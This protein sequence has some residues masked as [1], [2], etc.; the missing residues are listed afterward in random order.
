MIKKHIRTN[1]NEVSLKIWMLSFMRLMSS[2]GAY[3][4]IKYFM[5]FLFCLM[6]LSS[7][8]IANNKDSIIFTKT[9]YT[10]NA[11]YKTVDGDFFIYIYSEG[12]PEAV[13]IFKKYHDGVLVDIEDMFIGNNQPF[14]DYTSRLKYDFGN[15]ITISLNETSQKTGIYKLILSFDGEVKNITDESFLFLIDGD[16]YTSGVYADHKNKKLYFAGIQSSNS[17][18][19]DDNH[20]SFVNLPMDVYVY[21]ILKDTIAVAASSTHDN[22]IASYPIRVPNTEY[23]MY[24]KAIT[25]SS[26]TYKDPYYSYAFVERILEIHI[27]EIPEW[28]EELELQAT[29]KKKYPDAKKYFIDGPA[30]IRD[31]PKG[32]EITMLND[33]T[34]VLVLEQQ[35]GWYKLVYADVMGWTYKDNLRGINETAKN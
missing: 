30:S 35:G 31:N 5:L 16:W 7:C 27:K 4:M 8:A 15:N 19:N 9:G 10:L 6:I 23:L 26:Q 32:K 12:G 34:E 3:V 14:G 33:W 25:N 18:I 13:S 21:D 29:N 1:L 2:K 22:I 28:K 17:V 11:M 20:A 24:F